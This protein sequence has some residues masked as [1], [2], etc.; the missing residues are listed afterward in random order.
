MV[1]RLGSALD[2]TALTARAV[3][4]ESAEIVRQNYGFDWKNG[5]S[6]VTLDPAEE[7]YYLEVRRIEAD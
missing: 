2:F 7:R 6:S 4:T 5:I 1:T 3:N